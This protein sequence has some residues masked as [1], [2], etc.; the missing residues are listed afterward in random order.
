MPSA[1]RCNRIAK[2][3]ELST[4]YYLVDTNGAL[5]QV[6]AEYDEN[7]SLTTYY[8]RGEELISQ[9][10]N[11]VK[12]YYLYDG[13]DS[14]RMLTDDEGNVTDTYTFDAFGNLTESTGDTE[15]SYL[16]RGEQFDSF[17]GLYYLRARYM[18]PSTGTF[19]T[20][21]EYAGTIFEPVSLHKY[22]YA[23]ANP[24]NNS[25][26][27]GYSTLADNQV[28]VAGMA[29]LAST[30]TATCVIGLNL[31]N[32]LYTT[33]STSSIFNNGNILDWSEGIASGAVTSPE[34]TEDIKEKSEN[35]DD[36]NKEK[37]PPKDKKKKEK[38]DDLKGKPNSTIPRYNSKG[39]KIGERTFDSE[40]KAD[41]DTD[42]TDHSNP[43]RHPKVPHKHKWDWSDPANPKRI[44]WDL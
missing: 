7:G 32:S 2:I 13:F 37:T 30:I 20:M 33:I 18:N 6:L 43:K 1:K 9:E 26:P 16:Y 8:T 40:G 36:G 27:S 23:N 11:G 29:I 12:S 4:T 24:V 38:H 41:Y 19:I 25:D 42:F 22:L 34:I 28:A 14:V 5:S 21:D 44:S 3:D 17:T 31:L 35:S 39:Q 15:N 10:R